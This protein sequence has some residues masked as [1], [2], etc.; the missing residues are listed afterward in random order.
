ML[1]KLS[2]K[3]VINYAGLKY[4]FHLKMQVDSF[5][6]SSSTSVVSHLETDSDNFVT[7]AKRGKTHVTRPKALGTRLE[8]EPQNLSF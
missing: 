1:R 2:F 6:Q 4:G 8:T 5:S 7:G 3:F